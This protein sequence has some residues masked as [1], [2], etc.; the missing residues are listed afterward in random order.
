M[1]SADDHVCGIGTDVRA[2]GHEAAEFGQTHIFVVH[3]QANSAVVV[4]VRSAE[5]RGR[6]K[7]GL[8]LC[9]HG[10]VIARIR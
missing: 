10:D 9:A 4:V 8:A 3:A 6:G 7:C 1:H 2:V 5:I